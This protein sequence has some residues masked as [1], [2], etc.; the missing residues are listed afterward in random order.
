MVTIFNLDVTFCYS[1]ISNSLTLRL[2]QLIIPLSRAKGTIEPLTGGA[3]FY[4]SVFVVPKHTGNL[5][6]ILNTKWFSHYMYIHTFKMPST[7]QVQQHIQ[8]GDYAF[9]INLKDTYLH[10]LL[11]SIT[12]IFY[13]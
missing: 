3:G 11:L 12:I 8:Q 5:W 13:I 7:R 4:S 10:I 6:P 9:S 1:V 2:L